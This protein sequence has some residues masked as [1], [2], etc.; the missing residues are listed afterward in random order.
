ML[1]G[2]EERRGP[3]RRRLVLQDIAVIFERCFEISSVI[4]VFEC[5]GYL[6]CRGCFKTIKQAKNKIKINLILT[7]FGPCN[8]AVIAIIMI[9]SIIVGL[10]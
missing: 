3:D 5:T 6:R 9:I 1:V 10:R 8:I 4:I 7:I 2:R